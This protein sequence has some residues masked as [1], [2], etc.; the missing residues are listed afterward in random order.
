MLK[1]TVIDKLRRLFGLKS[2]SRLVIEGLV[3]ANEREKTNQ[4]K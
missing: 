1:Y 4:T 2:P 3:K